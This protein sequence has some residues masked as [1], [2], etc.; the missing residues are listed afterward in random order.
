MAADQSE[1]LHK[2]VDEVLRSE[3]G[4]TLFAHLFNICGYNASSTVVNPVTGEVSP[5]ATTYNEA[6]RGVY[7][8]LRRLASYDLLKAAEELAEKPSPLSEAK[9]KE[10]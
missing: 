9:S 7:L 3:A 6:R 10:K 5:E 4:R 2:S 1:K 8:H